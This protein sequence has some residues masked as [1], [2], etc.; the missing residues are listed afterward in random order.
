ML[1]LVY[2]VDPCPTNDPDGLNQV[3]EGGLR[4]DADGTLKVSTQ[5]VDVIWNR[6]VRGQMSGRL[7]WDW[8]QDNGKHPETERTHVSVV[9]S[10][11]CRTLSSRDMV[12]GRE[13]QHSFPQTIMFSFP[14]IIKYLTLHFSTMA[15]VTSLLMALSTGLGFKT[16]KVWSTT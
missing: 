9:L 13:S 8:F 14:E 1:R 4:S 5:E 3:G 10:T 7:K 16:L 11:T 2:L 12:S 6:P 15:A